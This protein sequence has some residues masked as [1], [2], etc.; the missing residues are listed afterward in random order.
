M[1]T[2]FW[3]NLTTQEIAKLSRNTI[4]I[5][6][7]SAIEQ[8]GSHLPVNTDQIILDKIIHKFCEENKKSKDFIVL[9]NLSIGSSSEHNNFQGTLSVDSINYISFCLNYLESIFSQKFKKFIFLNSHG[10]QI[11]H[12]DIIAKELKNKYKSSKIIK[13]NYFLF[14]G[15]N[16]IVSQNEL[17]YGYHGGEFETSLMLYLA[18]ELVRKNKKTKHKLSPDYNNKNIIGFEKNIKLQWSTEDINN[19]GIIGNPINANS[20]KGKDLTNIATSTIK[21]I[22]KELK[23]L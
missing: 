17:L 14:D 9:P 23:L 16:K 19:S 18:N 6:P 3:N 2:K 8:H 11:S 22:I 7:F 4:I 12:L 21:K 13:A 15:Y 10:G 5:A 1:L 20:Q